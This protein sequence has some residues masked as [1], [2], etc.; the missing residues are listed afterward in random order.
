LIH[1]KLKKSLNHYNQL[2]DTNILETNIELYR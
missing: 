1:V 2:N